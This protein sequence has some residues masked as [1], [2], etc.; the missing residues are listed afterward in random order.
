MVHTH[1]VLSIRNDGLDIAV[2]D[3][4]LIWIIRAPS[5]FSEAHIGTYLMSREEEDVNVP[6][7]GEPQ[8]K[9]TEM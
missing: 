2:K 9:W 5:L 7:I 4:R 8:L 3:L 1:R 6:L